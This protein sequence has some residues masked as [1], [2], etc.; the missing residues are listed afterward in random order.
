[1][2]KATDNS[3]TKLS[4]LFTDPMVRSAFERAGRDLGDDYAALVE[5]DDPRTLDGG[6]V[7]LL[8]GSGARR[9]PALVGGVAPMSD[10]LT[11]SRPKPKA[12]RLRKIDA[13]MRVRIEKAIQSMI[14][15]LDALDAPAE[16][17]EPRRRGRG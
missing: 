1:M 9:V 2:A 14:D 16:D 15:T 3:I 7:E 8:T 13:A 5:E 17:R 12:K 4:D 11:T 6:A 10:T